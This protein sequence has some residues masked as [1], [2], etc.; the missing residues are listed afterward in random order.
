VSHTSRYV[1]GAVLGA[2]AWIALGA[3]LLQLPLSARFVLAWLLF[4]FGPGAILGV[5]LTR[6][7]DGATRT[8][9][10]LGLGSATTPILVDVLGRFD[11][12]AAFPY[13]S[14]ALAGA[15]V[16]AWRGGREEA[17]RRMSRADLVA[18]G[19][20]VLVAAGLGATAFWNRLV[21]T[22]ETLAIYGD[23]DSFDLSFYAAWSAEAT[24]TVPPMASYYAGHRLNAAYYSQLILAMVHRFADVP[25][26]DIYFR[27]AWPAF[28]SLGA[29][30]TFVFVRSL[31]STGVAL[32]SGVLLLA[33]GDFSYLAAWFLP[34]DTFQW[35]YLL[36]PTNFLSP[37]ME[38]LQFNTWAPTLTVFFTAYYAVVRALRTSSRAWTVVAGLMM[39]LVF[40]FKPFSYVV[41]V[42]GLFAAALFPFRDAAARR[43]LAVICAL[44]IA[45]ALPF[46]YMAL[47]LPLEDRRTRLLIDFFQLPQRMLVKLDLVEPFEA[48]AARLAPVEWMQQPALMLLATAPFLIVGIGVRWFGV[49]GVWRAIRRP[50]AAPD[51]AVWR[52]LAWTIVAGVA[53]PFV[54]VTDPYVDTIQFYQAALYLL[55]IFTAVALVTFAR[56]R[57]WT[58]AVAMAVATAITLPSSIHYLSRKWTDETRPPLAELSVG[59]RHAAYYLRTNTDPRSTVVL[60][61]RATAPSLLTVLAER[62]VVLG[63]GPRYYAVGGEGLLAEVNAFFGSAEEGDPVETFQMLLRNGVTHVLVHEDRDRVHPDVLGRLNPL[64]RSENVTLYA[65]PPDEPKVPN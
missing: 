29:L 64:M 1:L 23:Y 36:W 25:L 13:A 15:G 55:W 42:G 39:G 60:H 43:R 30:S 47:T 57:P 38:V 51:A 62:R 6:D 48:L 63:W 14:M 50:D 28:L 35:D 19:L 46:A 59:A 49:P 12:L 20:L 4:T 34:H 5:W 45:F 44:T 54:L 40:Q 27:Y 26:L 31:A 18:C 24:H 10:L 65:V 61:D 7:L 33:G 37:T 2:C 8:I 41:L 32:L 3:F 16:A 17:P 58:G 21:D 56:R 22:P 52:V 9:V 11:I 53:T